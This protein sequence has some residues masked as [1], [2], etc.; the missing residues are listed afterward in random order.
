MSVFDTHVVV[1]LVI[2]SSTSCFDLLYTFELLNMAE[3]DE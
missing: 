3:S 1:C 2:L